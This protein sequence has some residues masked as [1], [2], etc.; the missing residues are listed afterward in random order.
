MNPLRV[1]LLGATGETGSSILQGL[2]AE[3]DKF[4]V[5]ALVRPT[6]V[7]KP[8]V[9][10]IVDAGVKIRVA[11]ATSSP[12]DLATVLGGVDILI[13]AIDAWS[14]L[15]QKNLATAAKMAGVKRFL[16]CAFT[17]IAPPGGV[18]L[19]RDDK[20]EVYEHVKSIG[21][22]YTI[23]DVGYWYQ[24]SFPTVPSGRVDYAAVLKHTDI[25]GDG[26]AP[27][28]LTDLRDIGRFVARIIVDDRTINQ[29]VYV[30]GEV[31][32]ENQIFAM[33]EE[34][35]GEKIQR[36]YVK[37]R[38]IQSQVSSAKARYAEKPYDAMSRMLMYRSQY[39]HSKY[40]RRDNQPKVAKELG[41]L[42]ARELYPDLQPVSFREFLIELLDGKITKPY[43][44]NKNM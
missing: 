5:E 35:S 4:Q 33:L 14:Q 11:D 30:W 41:Y 34:L 16:P 15:Q 25:H 9:K 23:V 29:Y 12:E 10:K 31:L 27:N 43:Y 6:S 17:T 26:E 32:T 38:E 36:N 28:L 13:S 42:D 39:K 2:L 37:D 7:E 20:E 1:A 18:M 40:V 8:Q 44:S 24:L 3:K 19:L 21:L 22:P